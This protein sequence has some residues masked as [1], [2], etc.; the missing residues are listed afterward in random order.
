MIL[1]LNKQLTESQ[2]QSQNLAKKVIEGNA[3]MHDIR[4][5]DTFIH[6]TQGNKTDQ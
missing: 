1:S 4:N 6:E 5:K 2:L 3:R